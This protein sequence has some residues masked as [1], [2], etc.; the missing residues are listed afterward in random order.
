[1]LFRLR[2]KK[3]KANYKSGNYV[4]DGKNYLLKEFKIETVDTWKSLKTKAI[5]PTKLNI[6]IPRFKLDFN[7]SAKIKNQE[8]ISKKGPSYW[9]GA[10]ST[11]NGAIG[12]LEMTGYDKAIKPF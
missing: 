10:I 2:D 7:V 4:K 8:F 12:Y 3:G 1:M 5:Y 9:E 6:K 11:D